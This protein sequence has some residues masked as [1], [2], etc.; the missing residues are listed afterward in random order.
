MQ[1]ALPLQSPP[2]APAPR[3]PA[4]RSDIEGL[5]AIAVLAV[6]VN[7]VSPHE[8]RGG[9]AGVDIFFVISGYLIGRHLLEDIQAGRLSLRGFYARRARRILPALIVMLTAVSGFGWLILSG[10]E[11][12]ALGKHVLAAALFSN[13]FL[14]WSESGYFDAPSLS[15]PLLHLW[16]LGIEEQF[17]LLAPILLWLGARGRS[18]SVR[19]VA[20]LSVA[21]LIWN[22]LRPEPSFYLLDTRFWE[23]G[24]GVILAH[25]SLGGAAQLLTA[26]AHTAR[27]SPAST[28]EWLAAGLLLTFAAVLCLSSRLATWQLTLAPVA[29]AVGALLLGATVMVVSLAQSCEVQER[30][31]GVMRRYETPLRVGSAGAGILCIGATVMGLG[32]IDWPGPQTLLPVLG[33]ALVIAGGPGTFLNKRLGWRPLAFIGGISYPLYLWHWPAIVYWR[34]LDASRAAASYFV[35][36]GA[37]L[38]LACLTK[39][40]VEEPI[41]FGRLGSR[42]IPRAPVWGLATGLLLM[43]LLGISA[44]E[45]DGYPRRF[46]PA[47]SAIA[48]WSVPNEDSAWRVHRCYRYPDDRRGYA[49]EC[50]PAKRS[51][52][53]RVLLW[54]DS[55]AAEL[56]TGLKGLQQGA[57][58]EIVQWTAAGCPPTRT[59]LVQEFAGCA[60]HRAAALSELPALAPDTVII[61]AAWELYLENGAS[62]QAILAAVQADIAWLQGTGVR[63]VVLF[64]PS[65]TWDTS[66]PVDLFRYMSLRR[67]TRIPERLGGPSGDVQRLDAA[68]AKEVSAMGA[69]YVSVLH[70]LCNRRGCRTLVAPQSATLKRPDLLFRDRDHLTMSGSRFL[71]DSV[72]RAIFP[73]LA[74]QARR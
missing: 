7:H 42:Q 26:Q 70:Q 55:H 52:V 67:T 14:L 23:L 8:L 12:A 3:Q 15:K 9:F 53:P 63:H 65:P 22:E 35:P 64:G 41:R 44:M 47:V 38:L 36:I 59:P 57:N 2:L 32:S 60:A 62:S 61:A 13:N 18:A 30:W 40:L 54:G 6:I 56:Y 71:I 10:P 39:Y 45:T 49:A 48:N 1:S 68:M 16:S 31:S 51:G 73:H 66:L 29:G 20:W 5:R 33:T 17:Y 43:G 27:P 34:M 28:P 74:V 21:S 25:L 50:T 69:S 46:P 19:W 37:A 24:A 72:A 58:F 4:I 11:L